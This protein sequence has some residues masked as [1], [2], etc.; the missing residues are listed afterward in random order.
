M[1]KYSTLLLSLL[2]LVM[3]THVSMAQDELQEDCLA[4]FTIQDQ[5]QFNK[6]YNEMK[7]SNFKRRLNDKMILIPYTI[8]IA[9]RSDGSGGVSEQQVDEAMER[10]NGIYEQFGMSFYQCGP[11]LVH[12]DDRLY[13]YDREGGSGQAIQGLDVNNTYNIY[14]CNNVSGACGFAYFPGGS[15]DRTVLANGCITRGTTLEHEIGHSFN[16]PHTHAGGGSENVARPGEGNANCNTRGD[17]FC[18]TEADPTLSGKSQSTA[19][20][21]M[22]NLGNGP[23]GLAYRTDGKNIMS[24]APR[25]DCRTV[26]SQEQMDMMYYTASTNS[27]RTKF[28]CP[29]QPK[30]EFRAPVS[31]ITCVGGKIQLEDLSTGNQGFNWNWTFNGGSANSTTVENPIVSYTSPGDYSV[32]LNVSNNRGNDTETKNAY[33]KVINPFTLPYE[34]NFSSGSSVLNNF[35]VRTNSQSQVAVNGAGGRS[36][37]G[38]ILTSKSRGIYYVKARKERAFHNNPAY[39]SSVTIPCLDATDFETLEL[40][41]DLKLLYNS[42]R[43]YTTF[44]I[45]INGEQLGQTYNLTS[46]NQENWNTITENIS[47]Y[48]GDH[49]YITFEANTRSAN[50]NAVLIDNISVTGEGGNRLK[51]QITTNGEALFCEGE[52]VELQA[53]IDGSGSF[54]YQWKKDGENIP[55][56]TSS[57]FK[58]TESGAYS[59]LMREGD[60]D[61]ESP[62]VAIQVIGKPA[63]PVVEVVPSCGPG[64]VTLKTNSES[65]EMNWYSS[66]SAS[67]PDF[68]GAVYEPNLTAT[69]ML[70]VQAFTKGLNGNVGPEDNTFGTGGIHQ[71]NQSLIFDAYK[72][73]ILKSAKVYAEEAKM[74]TLELKDASDQIIASKEIMIDAGESVVD[75]NL[76]IPAGSGYKIGFPDG[77]DLYRNDSDPAYPYTFNNLLSITSSTAG[78]DPFGFYYYLYNWDVEEVYPACAGDKVEVEARVINKPLAPNASDVTVCENS[79]QVT[80]EATT[81]GNGELRWYNSKTSS[82]VLETGSSYNIGEPTESNDYFVGEVLTE[83]QIVIGGPADN[84]FGGGGIHGGGFYLVFDATES[85]L[86]K[87]AKVYAEEEKV[88][89]LEVRDETGETII[90]SKEINIPA[91]ETRIPINLTLPAGVNLQIG[92]ASGADLFRNNDNVSYPYEVGDIITIK[93]STAGT[94][95]TGFYYYLYDWEVEVEGKECAG[96]RTEV[97]VTVEVCTGVVSSTEEQLVTIYPNPTEGLV[98][99][100]YDGVLQHIE[101]Q[102]ELGKTVYE[103]AKAIDKFNFNGFSAGIYYLNATINQKLY[104]N[105]VIVK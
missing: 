18:D 33:V 44:R 65:L 99:I 96:E 92:F 29:D 15:P 104:T 74:R 4:E 76:E 56:A 5:L 23:D 62:L 32:S 85:F 80:L 67:T 101:I 93:E 6:T 27:D 39:T 34:E 102:D 2:C 57:T 41:F 95:P 54:T 52:S 16:L 46:D 9:R 100:T 17:R 10:V 42:N 70:Y 13:N 73:F 49:V 58:A 51:P 78:S 61:G 75:I 63:D 83:T 97:A 48:V 37:D 36:G 43:Y 72:P 19:T 3:F 25:K 77:S 50:D 103:S 81:T 94:D 90:L 68:V 30:A 1:K 87:S 35:D 64:T 71:G 31:R 98:D 84:T 66:I 55:N 26:F 45:L 24:Y 60:V 8:H 12:R 20:C 28:T 40:K 7:K 91:G 21:D 88:R 105:K 82:D 69:E 14:F 79:G 59:V 53:T 47:G 38:L 86:L 11:K 89:T 22:S